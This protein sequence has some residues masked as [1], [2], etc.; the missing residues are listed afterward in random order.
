MNAFFG[1]GVEAYTHTSLDV[2]MRVC[3]SMHIS[4]QESIAVTLH[5]CVVCVQALVDEEVNVVVQ[6]MLHTLLECF[7]SLTERMDKVPPTV[8]S[9]SACCLHC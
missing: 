4:C 6:S 2:H 1:E 7:T 9:C 3:L 5:L 8:V